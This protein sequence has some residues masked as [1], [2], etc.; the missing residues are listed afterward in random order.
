[1]IQSHLP[2]IL[3][4]FVI[5][6]QADDEIV[7]QLTGLLQKVNVAH[8]KEIEG[9]NCNIKDKE[10]HGRKFAILPETQTEGTMIFYTQ[11]DNVLKVSEGFRARRNPYGHIRG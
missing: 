6:E 2:E 11:R 9:T 4:G 1:M 3:V 8:V 7:A 10:S 5:S